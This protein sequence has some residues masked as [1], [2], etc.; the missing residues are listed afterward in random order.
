ME[1]S[2]VKNG[3]II[4]KNAIPKDLVKKIQIATADSLSIISRKKNYLSFCNTLKKIKIK[5]YEIVKPINK[6]IVSEGLIS[7]ILFQKK[8]INFINKNLGS[9]LAYLDDNVLTLNLPNKSSSKLNYHFKDWHQ[10]LWSGSD[11]STLIFWTPIFQKDK[12]SGQI[13]FIIGSNKWGHVPH[14]NRKPIILPKSYKTYKT[15][16]N[17]GDIVCFTSLTLHRTVP[18]QN[19]RLALPI[20][21]RNFKLQNNSFDKNKN[22]KIFSYSDLTKIERY[23]GNH[24]LS[25][26]RLDQSTVNLNDG[27]LK[28]N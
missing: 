5:E 9:D 19:I 2:F 17:L 21:V 22:W 28:R 24:Y 27:V 3:Y 25:P 10:E 6:K 1:N 8:I 23:L 14:Q 4:F 7:E 12:N 16:L 18:A 13:E 20:L 15:K 11:L 26:F